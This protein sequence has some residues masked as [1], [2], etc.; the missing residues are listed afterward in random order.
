MSICHISSMR[1]FRARRLF[2]QWCISGQ[3][4]GTHPTGPFWGLL[5]STCPHWSSKHQ[6]LSCWKPGLQVGHVICGQGLVLSA[7][8]FIGH[9]LLLY[10]NFSLFH[11]CGLLPM[12]SRPGLGQAPCRDAISG[13]AIC[14]DAACSS[15][16]ASTSWAQWTRKTPDSGCERTE[17]S[18]TKTDVGCD[19]WWLNDPAT[20]WRYGTKI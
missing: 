6:L 14:R 16:L 7:G 12:P 17:S 20:D 4:A 10:S 13:D 3:S 5:G 15:A 2:P 11:V 8:V 18:S 1:G 9:V 19:K